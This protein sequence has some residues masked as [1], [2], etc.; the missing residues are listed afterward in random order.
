MAGAGKTVDLDLSFRA[1][2][3]TKCISNFAYQVANEPSLGLYRINEH[4]HVSV[5]KIRDQEKKLNAVHQRMNGC[6]FDVEYDCDAVKSMK[7]IHQFDSI[8]VK[9]KKA[10]ELKKGLN[11]RAAALRTV[12]QQ[13]AAAA[14]HSVHHSR[15]DYGSTWT[16]SSGRIN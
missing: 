16:N 7:G 13:P 8:N 3:L 2:R 4:V 1:E 6:T 10:I 9:M 5:P 11:E 14:G 15:K 12:R